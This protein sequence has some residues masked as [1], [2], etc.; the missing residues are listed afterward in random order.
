MSTGLN[1]EWYIIIDGDKQLLFNL[2]LPD[3]KFIATQKFPEY[4]PITIELPIN[5]MQKTKDWLDNKQILKDL[6]FI[7]I[8]K[9]GNKNKTVKIF[10]ISNARIQKNIVQHS[11]SY[12]SNVNTVVIQY[13]G[14]R[15]L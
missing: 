2:E 4:K 10:N 1:G 8:M 5:L 14:V 7:N 11:K 9:V 15:G 13:D 12:N 3:F 6:Y